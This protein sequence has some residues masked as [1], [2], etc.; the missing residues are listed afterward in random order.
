MN[1]YLHEAPLIRVTRAIVM[2]LALFSIASSAYAGGQEPQK[3]RTQ[4]AQPANLQELREKMQQLE[5]AM[6]ELKGQIDAV[7][8]AQRAPSADPANSPSDVSSRSHPVAR[9]KAT[10]A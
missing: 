8:E 10:G 1:S 2:A 3:A 7:E 6:Q 4:D 9:P 5:Q